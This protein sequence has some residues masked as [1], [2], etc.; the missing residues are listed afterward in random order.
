MLVVGKTR[1]CI[2]TIFIIVDDV[3]YQQP[4]LL[5][6][7]DL[8]FKIFHT[9]NAKYPSASEHIWTLI[10]RGIYNIIAANDKIFP[11]VMHLVNA[12]K[13]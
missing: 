3:R 11:N 7:L 1:K 2:E 6:G 5:K 8:L 9:F 4:T 10:Q 12:F 13:P